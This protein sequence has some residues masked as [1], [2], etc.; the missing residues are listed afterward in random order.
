VEAREASLHV[1]FFAREIGAEFKM[2]RNELGRDPGVTFTALFRTIGERF[3]VQGERL[4]GDEQLDA[5]FP[6]DVSVLQLFDCVIVGSF[7][8]DEWRPEQF[9]ALAGYVEQGGAVVFLG[10]ESSYNLGGYGP[11]PLAAMFPWRLAGGEPELLRGRFPVVIPPPAADL[12]TV[13]GIRELISG[14]AAPAAVVES[15]NLPGPLKPGAASMMNAGIGDR[16]VAV[17]AT[18]RFGEGRIL[19]FATNTFWKWARASGPLREAYGTL[20]RQAIRALSGKQ[21]GG[22]LL[23]VTWD[24]DAYRPGEEGAAEIRVAGGGSR[25][26]RFSATMGGNGDVKPLTV[27]P[28]PGAEGAFA[29]RTVFRERGVYEFRLTLLDGERQ[30]E[31]YEKVLSVQPL[32]GEGARLEVDEPFLAALAARGTGTYVREE[33][34]ETLAEILLER[35]LGRTMV[36]DVSLV[37]GSPWF[38]ALVLALL[39]A[40]W[41]LRRRHNLF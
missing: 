35:S 13:Y 9:D 40:E 26:L 16:I 21:E 33:D 4:A 5:G 24:R 10:G 29:T 41:M 15:L 18:L 17:L 34:V 12:P 22:R 28:V 37:S 30:L 27:E 14:E 20:W 23:A 25:G 7:P 39:V 19:A 3:T 31:T 38:I 36:S 32:L 6:A 11:T 8:A 2:L 1:L